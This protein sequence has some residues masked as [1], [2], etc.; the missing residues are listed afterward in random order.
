M[1]GAP[2]EPDGCGRRGAGTDPLATRLWARAGSRSP[3]RS[4][5]RPAPDVSTG[6][7]LRGARGAGELAPSARSFL[8]RAGSRTPRPRVP[9]TPGG[10][11]S[12]AL[13]AASVSPLSGVFGDRTRP[14][15][16]RCARG[17]SVRQWPEL[18]C[19][20]RRRQEKTSQP[21]SPPWERSPRAP[22]RVCENA[23]CLGNES[24][25]VELV[26]VQNSGLGKQ[27]APVIHVPVNEHCHR[28]GPT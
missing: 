6:Q 9:G 25:L 15:G 19:S 28:G 2:A 20:G 17:S 11:S 1:A 7:C 18:E 12:L 5:L 8:R 13:Y 24:V 14:G 16:T 10:V 22:A 23:G 26:A 21:R 4:G 27:G 3:L